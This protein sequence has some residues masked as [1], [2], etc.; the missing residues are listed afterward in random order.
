MLQLTRF[1]ACLASKEGHLACWI[2][3]LLQ[4]KINSAFK[5]LFDVIPNGL[6]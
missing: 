6:L 2:P 1:L 4:E 5:T 3:S